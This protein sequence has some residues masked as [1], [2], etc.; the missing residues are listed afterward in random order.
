MKGGMRHVIPPTRRSDANEAGKCG[1]NVST[2]LCRADAPSPGATYARRIMSNMAIFHH[3]TVIC[4]SAENGPT[5]R[6]KLSDCQF[7]GAYDLREVVLANV[8][9]GVNSPCRAI[10]TGLFIVACHLS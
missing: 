5:A 7:T 2:I 9:H 6:P 4:L 1:R 10:R 8:T 3:L